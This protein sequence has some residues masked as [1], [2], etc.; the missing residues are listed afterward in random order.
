[1]DFPP[2]SRQNITTPIQLHYYRGVA[3][4]NT[5]KMS[6]RSPRH[7]AKPSWIKDGA[8]VSEDLRA[9]VSSHT[10]KVKSE[11]RDLQLEGAE[12]LY[13]LIMFVWSLETHLARDAA[14]L[15]CDELR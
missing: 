11:A 12:Q 2:N 6:S 3:Y 14:D 10:E 7:Q 1:M 13:S 15:V 9:V 5:R 8:L 4:V